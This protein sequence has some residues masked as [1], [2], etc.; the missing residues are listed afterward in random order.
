M[1]ESADTAMASFR[2]GTLKSSQ[3]TTKRTSLG[4][5]LLERAVAT[6][7]ERW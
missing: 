4:V 6:L 7:R 2:E 3:V 1:I 5:I